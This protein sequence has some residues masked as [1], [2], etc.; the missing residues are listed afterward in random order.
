MEVQQKCFL[1]LDRMETRNPDLIA[2][3]IYLTIEQGGR[4]TPAGNGH[5][6]QT[7]FEGLRGITP[8]EQVFTDEREYI[9][10]GDSAEAKITLVSKDAFKGELYAGQMFEFFDNEKPVGTGT[11]LKV[12]NSELA[13]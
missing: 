4:R 12:L 11:I 2:R 1:S 8:A 10:P 13:R 6:P 9:L 3:V 7:K 5:R